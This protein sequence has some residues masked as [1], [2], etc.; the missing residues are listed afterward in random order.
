M[1]RKSA[2]RYVKTPSIKSKAFNLNSIFKPHVHKGAQV[3]L[4]PN[5]WKQIE[6]Y[7]PFSALDWPF[8]TYNPTLSA[9]TA[10]FAS[11]NWCVIVNSP[12]PL[13]LAADNTENNVYGDSM[14]PLDLISMLWSKTRI[15]SATVVL[16]FGMHPPDTT[17]ASNEMS[18]WRAVV[19]FGCFLSHSPVAKDAWSTQPDETT[20]LVEGTAA[21]RLAEAYRAGLLTTVP[22]E[23]G[24]D[25]EVINN[26]ATICMKEINVIEQFQ[27][28]DNVGTV[29]E[30]ANFATKLPMLL[31]TGITHN[32]IAHPVTRLYLHP[33]II[34]D[35]PARGMGNAAEDTSITFHCDVKVIQ[36]H[37]FSDPRA[38]QTEDEEISDDDVAP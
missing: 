15:T 11:N 17:L 10:T 8:E 30:V 19:R 22:L 6:H 29:P 26:T 24:N 38:K 33:F 18:Y 28:E 35:R 16:V 21:A 31:E 1:G 25:P 32:S 2:L 7:Q 13:D 23:I 34:I 36:N 37:L 5:A 4:P 9:G 20:G 14:A 27:P 12:R 3:W